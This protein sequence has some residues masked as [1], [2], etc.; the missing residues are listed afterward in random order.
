MTKP[1]LATLDAKIDKVEGDVEELQQHEK[2]AAEQPTASKGQKPSM[3][4]IVLVRQ[5][6]TS[7]PAIVVNAREDGSIDVQIFKADH[8]LHGAHAVRE[9]PDEMG[10]GWLWPPRV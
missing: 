2:E 8:T 3:G 7:Y 1:T 5:S 6:G 9:V 4:R 10:D